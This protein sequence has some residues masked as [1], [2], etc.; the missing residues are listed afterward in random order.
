[1]KRLIVALSIAIASICGI[2]FG[3]GTAHAASG[4]MMCVYYGIG[5]GGSPV[6]L[7]NP[8]TYHIQGAACYAGVPYIVIQYDSPQ[9]A[10]FHYD[11]LGENPVSLPAGSYQ[12]WVPANTGSDQFQP[13]VFHIEDPTYGWVE[14]DTTTNDNPYNE[15]YVTPQR[16]CPPAIL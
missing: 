2:G 7:P 6:T 14:S 15:V 10:T 16:F 3:T 4:D 9:G 5:C 13:V 8:T 11:N 12:W 1:M